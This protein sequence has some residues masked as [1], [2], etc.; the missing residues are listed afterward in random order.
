MTAMVDLR[1]DIGPKRL[2]AKI[3]AGEV[4][5]KVVDNLIEFSCPDC[6]RTQSTATGT[7]PSHVLHRFN[8]VGHLVETVIVP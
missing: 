2:F 4:D 7:R 3:T 1:C 5:V 8:L 6:R